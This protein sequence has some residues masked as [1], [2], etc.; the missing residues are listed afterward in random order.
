M[1][2]LKIN[3][4]NFLFASIMI[5]CTLLSSVLGLL[6]INI[7]KINVLAQSTQQEVSLANKDFTDDTVTGNIK[8]A[9]GWS[10]PTTNSFVTSGIISLDQEIFEKQMEDSYKLSYK[11]YAYDSRLDDQ[12]LLINSQDELVFA[13]YQSP[14]FTLSENSYY[15]I[16]FKAYTE[17][18][19]SRSTLASA[20]LIGNDT[21]EQNVLSIMTSGY[22][23]DY[24][25][26]VETGSTEDVEANLQFWLGYNNG[27]KSYGS[28]LFDQVR[29]YSMDQATYAS[30][31]KTNSTN[32]NSIA[33]SLKSTISTEQFEN[34]DFENDTL[35]GWTGLTNNNSSLTNVNN[36]C[37]LINFNNTNY[38]DYKLSTALDDANIYNNTKA[39][40]INSQES[41]SVGYKSSTIAIEQHQTYKISFYAYA[42]ISSGS[43]VAKLVEVN[44]FSEKNSSYAKTF[45]IE[46][47]N[48]SSDE[49]TNGWTLYSFYIQGRS[50]ED[51]KVFL[52]I[53][54]GE[55]EKAVGYIA[56]DEVVV[57]KVT[58]NE[59]NSTSSSK[60]GVQCN[61]G[62]SNEATIKNGDFNSVDNQEEVVSYPYGVKDWTSK[63]TLPNPTQSGIINT[64]DTSMI[65]G[66]YTIPS[67]SS[68]S[69]NNNIL[70]IGNKGTNA[71]TY[72]SSSFSLSADSYY[73]LS[74]KVLT[75]QLTDG[76][77]AGFK[78]YT[79]S[80]TLKE[81][82]M[83]ESDEKWTTYTLYI[84]TGLNSYTAS[85][86]L[87]L[88][89]KHNGTGYA[90]FD[91]VVLSESSEDAFNS[92]L[93]NNSYR[94]NLAVDELTNT[95]DQ[96]VSGLYD[97][98]SY[99][100]NNV[101]GA[102]SYN[103]TTGVI[104]TNDHD[105]FESYLAGITNPLLPQG[106]QG[107]VLMIRSTEDCNYNWTSNEEFA[108]STGTFYKISVWVYTDG[109][110][111]DD[112]NKTQ[113]EKTSDYYPYGATISLT[114]INKEFTGIDTNG[115]WKE[116]TFYINTTDDVEVNIK[117]SLG[118]AN[119]L[120]KGT[121]FFTN[122][123]VEEIEQD[124]YYSSIKP[125]EDD[126]T[127]DNIMAIGSTEVEEDDEEDTDSS[128]SD[129]SFDW[130][131][132]PTLITAIALIIAVVAVM[133]RKFIKK[134]PKPVKIG[135]SEYNRDISLE[136]EFEHREAIRKQREKL[137]KLKQSLEDVKFEIAD[138]R[139]E[140]RKQHR[141]HEKEIS[142]QVKIQKSQKPNTKQTKEEIKAYK[143]EQRRIFK[144]QKYNEYLVRQ[145]QLKEKYAAIEIEIEAIYQEELK[146]I[147]LYKEYRKQV[148]Q[149][150]RELKEEKKAQKENKENKSKSDFEQ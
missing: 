104:D 53:W 72:T 133:I 130:L 27:V 129:T 116:Y 52:E 18:S 142:K 46:L 63:T 3:I 47:T 26:L 127:I 13:N 62:A 49:Y 81:L 39:L 132:I 41:A 23:Q 12:V 128:E 103:I 87:S 93:R 138:A 67:T 96:T 134:H 118:N 83:I 112:E 38:D 70:M 35:T 99:T 37:G 8:K 121:V 78:L 85:I 40:L 105:A 77:T 76:A 5:A 126:D 136:K 123:S 124:T 75:Q 64:K 143:R 7:S 68:Y 107:N 106:K 91:D 60:N 98:N 11:P 101:S 125:L 44:P 24:T 21:L 88:G 113:I 16:T 122:I 4:K 110:S 135:T 33:I 137:E 90:F 139:L 2:K 48:S 54:L 56:I 28:V 117:L 92:S 114:E 15:R 108:L 131:I 86:D 59:Y 17:Q 51:T 71:Q 74:F 115:K 22:W 32:K 82:M 84:K 1:T 20:N 14:S 19:D 57:S 31:I 141:A 95:N 145:Q 50:F 97:T 147:K 102:E 73:K 146:L 34:G 94:V 45:S 120:T 55:D 144:E 29:I 61:F 58:S 10:T 69:N 36:Y 100:K 119:A 149:K 109:L 111:Q 140:F 9:T 30:Y 80:M 25:I 43:A 79:S 66:I 42:N 6:L 148:R 65:S 150:R 89:V